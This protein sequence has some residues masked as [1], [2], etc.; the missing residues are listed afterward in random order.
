MMQF[1]EKALHHQRERKQL[2]TNIELISS[3]DRQKALTLWRALEEKLQNSSATSST[4]W[5]E[6]W[7]NHFGDAVPHTFIFQ[8]N[9]AEEVSGATIL[10]HS[11]Q[12]PRRGRIPVRT[13]SL[14]TIGEP[15]SEDPHLTDLRLLVNP[16]QRDIF[17]TGVMETIKSLPWKWDQFLL[18]GF[19][20]ED[21]TALAKAGT[22][23]GIPLAI[24]QINFPVFNFDRAREEGFTDVISG[25]R[26]NKGRISKNKEKLSKALGPIQGELAEDVTHAQEIFTELVA[27]NRNRWGMLKNEP[28][29]FTTNK[30]VDYYRDLI[31]KLFPQGKASVYRLRAGNTTLGC[32]LSFTDTNGIMIGYTGGINLA[33]KV[34]FGKKDERLANYTPG[35]LVHTA[36]MEECF[37]R[38]YRQYDFGWGGEKYK[39][40]LSNAEDAL[41]FGFAYRGVKGLAVGAARNI[42]YFYRDNQAIEDMAKNTLDAYRQYKRNLGDVRGTGRHLANHVGTL[43]LEMVKHTYAFSILA[44]RETVDRVKQKA[45]NLRRHLQP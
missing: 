4:S 45:S 21:T 34:N 29:F 26:T 23:V 28:G 18:Q 22:Q 10:T 24:R 9:D 31:D 17:A 12:H 20:P 37:Q 8:R 6:V 30:I 11:I 5:L 32:I 15:Q 7:L 14:G 38:G 3:A 44:G 16:Q 33:Q 36:Y 41:D 13:L 27:L 42:F 39:V 1:I 40:D 2:P 35:L 25:L 19:D 43:G